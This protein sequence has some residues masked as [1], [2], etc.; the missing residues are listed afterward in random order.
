M[1]QLCL[2]SCLTSVSHTK[3]VD[4][5]T[6]QGANTR[7]SLLKSISEHRTYRGEVNKTTS[8]STDINSFLIVKGYESH[9]SLWQGYS[10]SD[11]FC[12]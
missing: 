3:N 7:F 10:L 9:N 2:F 8:H 12:T 11:F 6:Q 4:D 1:A 5:C